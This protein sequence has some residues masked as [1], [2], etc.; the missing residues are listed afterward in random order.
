MHSEVFNKEFKPS[1]FHD[2]KIGVIIHWGPYS[3]PGWA[4]PL[5]ELSYIPEVYGW[6]TWFK[7]NPYAEW[8]YNSM[9]IPDSATSVYHELVFKGMSYEGFAKKFE[10]LSSSWRASEW[11]NLFVKS[12]IKY[13]VFVTKH[14]DGYL[15][16]PSYVENPRKPGWKSSRDYV[17]ELAKECR[18]RGLRFATYYS[19]GIDWTFN[20]TVIV[21]GDTLRAA[22]KFDNDYREYVKKHWY[23]LIDMYK[24]DILW[25]D[26]GYPFEEDLPE[27]FA[28]YYNNF[29]EGLVNDRFTK[30]HF[31]F[32]TPEYKLIHRVSEVKWEA[33]RGMG[34]SFGYNRAEGFEHTLSYEKAVHLLIDV[35][36]KNGNLLLGVTPAADGSIPEHQVDVLLKL[37]LWLRR[38]GEAVYGSR[39]WKTA[40]GIAIGVEDAIPLRF[41]VKNASLF[42][43]LLGRPRS[44]KLVLKPLQGVLEAKPGTYVEMIGEEPVNWGRTSKG[45]EVEIPRYLY[46]SPAYVLKVEPIP[47]LAQA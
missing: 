29:E 7:Y 38:Y 28:Y 1:W 3:V 16:W 21:D 11:V 4:T 25:N 33:V 27:L 12:G 6:E 23:E 14:H 30:K 42:V 10:D 31:D 35:V 24:P 44:K 37:G 26:M 47:S 39:P 20:S 8:Y 36:S 2:A 43:F 5:G 13:V 41:V 34:Y 19:S 18:S 45:L 40:E 9:R 32:V 46:P 15:L 17:G 22:S